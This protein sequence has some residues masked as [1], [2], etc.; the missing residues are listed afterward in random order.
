VLLELADLGGR[1]RLS[2]LP[3]HAVLVV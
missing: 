2:S 1:D 3:V